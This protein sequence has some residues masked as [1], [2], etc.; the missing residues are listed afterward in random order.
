VVLGGT[1]EIALAIVRELVRIA[2]RDVVLAGRDPERLAAAA[3]AVASAG[4]T[5]VS[6]V[7]VDAL[8]VACHEGAVAEAFARMGGADL[9]LLA[10]GVLG[11]RGGVPRD[12]DDALEV[13][14]VNVVGAGSLL[15]RAARRL[16]LQGSG[17]IVVLSSVAGERVRASNVVYGAAKAGLDALAL[18]LAD[19]LHRD[20]VRVMVVRPGFVRTRM[21]DGLAPAPLAAAPADV[22]AA[23]VR[24]LDRGAGVVWTPTGL[25]WMMLVLRLLPR[26]IVR[27]LP[28]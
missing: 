10:V 1:S 26:S 19:A 22:A 4:A 16:Q 27:A 5:S 24:G 11:E 18:G 28:I 21:T 12:V 2:P 15:I 3:D 25:R 23:V 20:G 17:T 13:L 6:T 7:E 8:E 9:V 14:R